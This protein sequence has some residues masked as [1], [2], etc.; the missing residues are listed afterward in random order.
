MPKYIY[1]YTSGTEI[2][3]HPDPAKQN[4]FVDC[5]YCGREEEF[6][7]DRRSVWPLLV[8]CAHAKYDPGLVGHLPLQYAIM[9]ESVLEIPAR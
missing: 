6:V 7:V 2:Y 3:T 5:P 1:G 4:L 9:P 8:E